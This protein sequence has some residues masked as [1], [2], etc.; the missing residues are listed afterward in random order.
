MNGGRRRAR[1]Q[2]R[3]LRSLYGAC[4]YCQEVR[5]L[6]KLQRHHLLRRADGGPS[7]LDNLRPACA[8]CH[9]TVHLL[10]DSTGE[11]R[12]LVELLVLAMLASA[13]PDGPPG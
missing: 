9:Q 4:V 2:I 5:G 8:C 10:E 13:S 12:R 3:A 7:T 1:R 6:K 11:E